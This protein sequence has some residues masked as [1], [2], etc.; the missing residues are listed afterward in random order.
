MN[1]HPIFV[2][3]P[4][5][6]FTFYALFEIIR[7]RILTRQTWYFYLKAVLVIAGSAMSF[8]T[9]TTGTMSEKF[10]EGHPA[11]EYH[12]FFAWTTAGVFL[13]IA[14]SYLF[15]WVGRER[16]VQSKFWQM[17]VGCG[18][19]IVGSRWIIALAI[20]GFVCVT[21]AGG[22]GGAMVFGPDADALFK[23]IYNLLIGK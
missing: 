11:L 18:E 15:A 8:I 12:E 1:I 3:F 22:I 13:A 5:A 20:L 4:I 2:H 6:L 9:I 17:W 21:S 7:L 10:M 19:R 23:P 16:Q 14:L